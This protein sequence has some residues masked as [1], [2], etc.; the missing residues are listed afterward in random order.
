M[1]S[2]KSVEPRMELWGT[3]ALNRYPCKDF[4]SRTIQS[5]LLLRKDQIRPSI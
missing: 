5:R 3:L 4:P 2:G 1:H